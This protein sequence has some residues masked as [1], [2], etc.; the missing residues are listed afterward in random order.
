[1][2]SNAKCETRELSVTQ[3]SRDLNGILDISHTRCNVLIYERLLTA[4]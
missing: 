1:V 4:V 2:H 3:P